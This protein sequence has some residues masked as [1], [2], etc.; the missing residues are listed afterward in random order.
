MFGK[1]KEKEARDIPVLTIDHFPGREYEVI[2]LLTTNFTKTSLNITKLIKLNECLP[3]I[4]KDAADIQADAVIGL[5]FILFNNA[6]IYA[7]GTAI[8][9]KEDD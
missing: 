8:R 6:N 5:R 4:L 1:P 3:D 2:G 9:F 7:Y